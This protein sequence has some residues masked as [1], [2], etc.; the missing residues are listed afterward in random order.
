MTNN[1]SQMRTG[2]IDYKYEIDTMDIIFKNGDVE[3][4][5]SKLF[6]HLY[7]EKDFDNL[8]FPIMNIGVTM[9]DMLY[10]R[11][12]QEN[13]SVK[14]RVRLRKRLY[15]NDKTF[16]RAE[17][18]F[19]ELFVVFLD[20]DIK[21]KDNDL[22]KEVRSSD[23]TDTPLRDRTQVRQFYLFK[24][25]V[26]KCKKIL[27]ISV[28]SAPITELIVYLMGECEIQRL[29]MSK[30]D[31][32]SNVDNILIPSGNLIECINHLN[33]VKGFYNAGMTLFF[34]IDTAYLL[35]RLATYTAWRKNEVRTTHIHVFDSKS[36]DGNMTGVFTD[37][38]RKSN[39]VFTN[40]D[41]FKIQN[42]NIVN[43]QL[44]GNNI[45]I[46]NPKT[47]KVDKVDE[48]LTQVGEANKTILYSKENNPYTISAMKL[49]M[50]EN[51]NVVTLSFMGVDMD[52]FTPNKEF[53]MSF[54][55]SNFNK[56]YGGSYRLCKFINALKKD[57][58][59]FVGELTCVFKKQK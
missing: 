21:I 34:D 23:K 11:I 39:H 41:L 51:E 3:K 14:F 53:I 17:Q 24:E 9:S 52:T 54:S 42:M 22:D 26:I 37:R 50:K 38:D 32:N 57:G 35:N 58:E 19:D 31:N 45:T 1:I 30:L 6:S 2:R 49:A 18:Q 40:T 46:V 28:S 7:M 48:K 36:N 29:L 55:D 33:E 27:N 59:E 56:M 13:H 15:S 43:D 44:V 10:D 4:V 8:F 5:E 12:I 16:I 47:N 20:S 25:D